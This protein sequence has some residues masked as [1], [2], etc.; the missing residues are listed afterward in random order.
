MCHGMCNCGP[1][2]WQQKEWT[3]EDKLKMLEKYER[4]MQEELKEVQEMKEE[5]AKQQ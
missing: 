3:R 5:L 1:G 2:G 4:R